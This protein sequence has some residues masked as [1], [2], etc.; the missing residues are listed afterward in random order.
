MFQYQCCI[1]LQGFT[2]MLH[3]VE[4]VNVKMCLALVLMCLRPLKKINKKYPDSLSPFLTHSL[5]PNTHAL[6]GILYN[7]GTV[8]LSHH[9]LKGLMSLSPAD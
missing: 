3:D 8:K 2:K 6:L 4:I 1:T 5:H 9:S 7:F